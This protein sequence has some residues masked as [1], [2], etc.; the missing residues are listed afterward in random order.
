[1]LLL[2]FETR[3]SNTGRAHLGQTGV[4][5]RRPSRVRFGTANRQE[6]A[7]TRPPRTI[8]R[9]AM[10]PMWAPASGSFFRAA[11]NHSEIASLRA[12]YDHDRIEYGKHGPVGR[13]VAP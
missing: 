12:Q 13:L 9:P 5:L 10:T 11:R 7:G 4:H 1:M 3:I 8:W 2:L 6:M